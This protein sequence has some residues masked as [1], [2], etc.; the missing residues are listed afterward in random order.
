MLING[1]DISI[2][3]LSIDN[4]IDPLKKRENNLLLRDRHIEIL[5]KYGID[6]KMHAS[7]SSLIFEI[8]EI[9]NYESDL[10]DLEAL[11]D[12][13]SEINYYNYTNK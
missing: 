8:E 3:S 9:L 10:D 7:L 6:Y 1:N 12:E 11:S 2:D 5:N 13:L 4:K